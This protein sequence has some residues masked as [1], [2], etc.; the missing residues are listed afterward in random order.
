[1]LMLL[2]IPIFYVVACAHRYLQ[3]FAPSNLLIARVRTSPPRW[4]TV[5]LLMALA[6]ALVGAMHFLST[7]IENGAPGWLNLL[8][9]VLAW[10]AIKIG[11]LAVMATLRRIRLVVATAA[12][13]VTA[14]LSMDSV[15]LKGQRGP[16]G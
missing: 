12:Q 14:R 15:V 11:L 8:V 16:T 5:M 2:F 1:M 9:M 6:Y 10:D 4:R 3:L 13:T 7:A